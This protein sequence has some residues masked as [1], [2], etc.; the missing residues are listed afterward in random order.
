[1]DIFFIFA[2]TIWANKYNT[3]SALVRETDRVTNLGLAPEIPEDLYM[4]IKKVCVD[5]L[6]Q[7]KIT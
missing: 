1:M 7:I 4:L 3:A 2:Y 6:M 5:V